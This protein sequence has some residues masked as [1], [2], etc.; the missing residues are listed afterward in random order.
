MQVLRRSRSL[1]PRWDGLAGPR[2]GTAAGTL[3][4]NCPSG[5]TLLSGAAGQVPIGQGPV[6]HVRHNGKSSFQVCLS[7]G[8]TREAVHLLLQ[9]IDSHIAVTSDQHRRLPCS[10]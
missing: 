2:Y 1:G 10:D 4:V 8:Q 5:Y 6:F 3:S 9:K 7:S